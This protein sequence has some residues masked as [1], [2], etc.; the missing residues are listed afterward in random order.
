MLKGT[1]EKTVVLRA[2]MSE[3]DMELYL[4]KH[5]C[6][7]GDGI[8]QTGQEHLYNADSTQVVE[9]AMKIGY[10]A[11]MNEQGKNVFTNHK[12]MGTTKKCKR[13]DS[14]LEV[15]TELD[16]PYYCTE[17]D[18]NLYGFETAPLSI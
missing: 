3:E 7:L 10:T 14:Q 1:K 13:C 17:C 12:M 9:M 6:D 5:G 18:E 11:D 4:L 15:E 8:C 2:V 16:Y